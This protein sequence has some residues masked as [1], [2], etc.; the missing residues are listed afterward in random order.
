MRRVQTFTGGCN[1]IGKICWIGWPLP[2]FVIAWCTHHAQCG[3]PLVAMYEWLRSMYGQLAV[4]RTRYQLDLPF[5]PNY[6]TER[7]G[8]AKSGGKQSG[9]WSGN[10]LKRCF[11]DRNE[12]KFPGRSIKYRFCRCEYVTLVLY[13]IIA[14]LR[15][16]NLSLSLTTPLSYLPCIRGLQSRNPRVVGG[17]VN[18]AC[19][20]RGFN[21]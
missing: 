14:G 21:I 7:T 18:A 8:F 13:Y 10:S 9:M 4:Q 16:L 3:S 19:R 12:Q 1:Q 11:S 2:L 6:W 15:N 5:Q 17:L 20:I